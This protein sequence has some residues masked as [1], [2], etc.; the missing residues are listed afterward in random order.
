MTT[1]DAPLA[2]ITVL[3]LSH[4]YA[5]PFTT[6]MMERAGARV[7]KV[8][9]P[10]G[11]HLRRRGVVPGPR[12]AFAMLNAGKESISLDLKSESGV[13]VFKRLV[14]AADVVVENFT[15]GVMD[16]LGIGWAVLKQINP[17][18]VYAQSSGYGSTGPYA[19]YPAMDLTV[20]AMAGIVSATGF[21]ETDPVKSGVALCDFSAGMNLYGAVTTALFQRERT[22]RGSRVEVSMIESV[23]PMLM[24]SLSAHYATGE[25]VERVGNQH[26]GLSVAPYSV[27]PTTDGQVAIT[28]EGDHHWRALTSLM[29]RPE[30]GTDERFAGVKGRVANRAQV[31]ALV[32]D[33]TGGL[34]KTDAFERMRAAGIPSAPVRTIAEVAADPHL[35]ARGYL[36]TQEHPKLG[37]ITTMESPIT[38]E[39]DTSSA[40]PAPELHSGDEQV[41]RELLSVEPDE[42]AILVEAGAFG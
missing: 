36:R 15:P 26:P 32:A 31:D 22:G 5:A 21:P 42:Y 19:E 12:Y 14:A 1:V 13:E 3:D 27:Y 28:C 37:Q 16:R 11:E 6:M 35:R 2:G 4:V 40:A 29:G 10:L 20:Q 23:F 30:L 33:W 7:I 9:P 18:L 39:G 34:T 38:F 41:L 8:E 24:S 17:R 25:D